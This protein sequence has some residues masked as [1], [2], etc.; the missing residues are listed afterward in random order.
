MKKSLQFLFLFSVVMKISSQIKIN[1][2]EEID[3][4]LYHKIIENKQYFYYEVENKSEKTFI[5]DKINFRG[6]SSILMD[7][8]VLKYDVPILK[9]NF[10]DRSLDECKGDFIFI[11]PKE[12]TFVDIHVVD[13]SGLFKKLDFTKNIHSE[14]IQ[15]ITLIMKMLYARLI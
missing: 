7:G 6:N 2:S 13:Y 11:H 12:K 9:G 14:P 10:A 3:V 4:L 15:N 8:N 1:R 5:I